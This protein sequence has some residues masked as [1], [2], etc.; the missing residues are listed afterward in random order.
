[1][2]IE[3]TKYY[4]LKCASF[5]SIIKSFKEGTEI[6]CII[7]KEF[8]ALHCTKVS[9][10]HTKFWMLHLRQ[11]R[12]NFN[13]IFEVFESCIPNERKWNKEMVVFL[14]YDNS[15][16][17]IWNYAKYSFRTSKEPKS[18]SILQSK[19]GKNVL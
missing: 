12:H 8:G 1:M 18:F 3:E 17:R 10:I 5:S 16:A 11:F 9:L 6:F 15:K 7:Y 4:I 14:F 19:V 2:E 13:I